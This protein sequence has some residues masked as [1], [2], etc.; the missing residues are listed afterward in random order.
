MEKSTMVKFN[1][2]TAI[3][4]SFVLGLILPLVNLGGIISL[5]AMGFVAT[6]LTRPEKTSY[7]VGGIAT[8]VFC[9][10]F[11]FFGFLTPPTLPYILPNPLALGFVVAF[12]GIFNL[13]LSLIVSVIIYGV[14]GLLGGYIAVRFFLEKKEV[15]KE[16]KPTKP[17][18]SLKR[19]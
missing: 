7:K 9:V 3:G 19:T 1:M 18:K 16:F 6:Y 17:N 5:V 10:F 13:I 4:I 12:S 8:K 2:E 14:F 15:K 11:F